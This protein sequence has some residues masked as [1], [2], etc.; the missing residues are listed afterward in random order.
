MKSI[1]DPDFVYRPWSDERRAAARHRAIARGASNVKVRRSR[2]IELAISERTA[3]KAIEL[4]GEA[5]QT[6]RDPIERELLVAILGMATRRL[7]R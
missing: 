4:C 3:A 1:G 7:A 5:L 2:L 6:E